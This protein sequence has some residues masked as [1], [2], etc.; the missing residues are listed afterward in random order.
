MRGR[1]L[2]GWALGDFPSRGSGGAGETESGRRPRRGPW[3][4]QWR[5]PVPEARAWAEGPRDE[6][7]SGRGATG[8][9]D[10]GRAAGRQG[11]GGTAAGRG[12]SG[13]GLVPDAAGFQSVVR[14]APGRGPGV[15]RGGRGAAK[16]AEGGVGGAQI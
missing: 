12:A 10:V 13:P 8:A 5:E 7:S 14:D 6:V 4:R 16:D 9:G 3:R 11:S 15:H 1:G 2:E